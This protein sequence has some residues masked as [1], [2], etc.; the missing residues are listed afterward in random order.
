MAL[1]VT[2]AS[3]NGE[4]VATFESYAIKMGQDSEACSNH[5]LH[6]SYFPFFFFFGGG[7]KHGLFP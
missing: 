6:G 7:V 3:E 4:V 1:N 2:R 5:G